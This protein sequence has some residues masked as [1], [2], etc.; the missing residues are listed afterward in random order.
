MNPAVLD[1]DPDGDVTLTLRSHEGE[2]SVS[3]GQLLDLQ[4]TVRDARCDLEDS[5]GS[6]DGSFELRVSSKHLMLA[7]PVL[8]RFLQSGFREGEELR[9]T[10]QAR[11]T[12][13][14][15]DSTALVIF[16]NIIHG[17]FNRVPETVTLDTFTEIAILADK[18]DCREA[19]R[20]LIELWSHDLR[21]TVPGALD[22]DDLLRWVCINWTF[23]RS[24][25]LGK[26][27]Q[28]ASLRATDRIESELPMLGALGT[29]S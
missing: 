27:T 14:D 19:F 16:F 23:G 1:P 26:I 28:I 12:L 7:S 2:R 13:E 20:F 6:Q 24:V 3:Q 21:E 9:D 11:L 8:R 22:N 10:G 5:N 29:H 4:E 18:Y 25:E 15:D 17:H